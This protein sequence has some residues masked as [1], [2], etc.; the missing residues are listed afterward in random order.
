MRRV[1]IVEDDATLLEVLRMAF[2]QS[3]W[4]VATAQSLAEGLACFVEER[5]QVV[6]TDKNLPGGHI[7]GSQAGVELVRQIRQRDRDVAIV[8]MTAYGTAESARDTLN[9]GID[10]YLEKPFDD[11]F[12]VVARLAEL[13]DRAPRPAA[14][15]LT[16]II[17]AS[18]ERQE[19][20]TNALG[21]SGDRV[22]GVTSPEAIRPSAKQEHA[23]VVV[24]DG[25]S[26]PEEITCL[27]VTVKTRARNAACVVLSQDLPL[28]DVKRLIELE[29]KALI[30]APLESPAFARELG[31]AL[32]RL[33]R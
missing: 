13:A 4:E 11:V 6:I 23:D 15:A 29:V 27:A 3:G 10:E 7:Q 32:G 5:P 8:L 12:A 18:P 30:E 17:A 21:Q 16:I 28:G 14:S 25:A 20:I 1:L 31:A 19:A 24:L 33:R 9:L 26:F 22:F 2:A